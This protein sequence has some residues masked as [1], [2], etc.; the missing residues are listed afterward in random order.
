M[1]IFSK[2]A[3]VV[4]PE[5]LKIFNFVKKFYWQIFCIWI[6][7]LLKERNCQLWWRWQFFCWIFSGF[8]KKNWANLI[9]FISGQTNFADVIIIFGKFGK[10]FS[11]WFIFV[12]K[13]SPGNFPELFPKFW[14]IYIF[15]SFIF[16][17]L[18]FL[19]P[20]VKV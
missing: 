20:N 15:V 9:E 14:K 19:C 3:C 4:A 7:K 8:Q 10:K 16:L 2:H 18:S 13:F 17:S 11:A 12:M 5:F 1:T 6:W